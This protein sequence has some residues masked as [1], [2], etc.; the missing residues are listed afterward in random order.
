MS[1]ECPWRKT[2]AQLGLRE[3]Y[4]NFILANS[5]MGNLWV[6]P[7]N[8]SGLQRPVNFP[9]KGGSLWAKSSQGLRSYTE[10]AVQCPSISLQHEGQLKA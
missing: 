6:R 5:S 4:L 8:S 3:L 7:D 10:I 1:T 9:I 2:P